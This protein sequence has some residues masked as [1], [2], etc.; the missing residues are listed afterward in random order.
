[1]KRLTLVV[2]GLAACTPASAL[3]AQELAAAAAVPGAA[4]ED[5][6]LAE[7]EAETIVVTGQRLEGAVIGDIPPEVTFSPADIRSFGVSSLNDL[8]AELAPQTGSS[9]GR[10]GESPVVLL[11][12]KR[13]SGFS[14]IRDIPTEAIQRVEILP[15]E[16]A[17]KYGYRATQ[18]V[19]N[20]V[21]RKRFRA[22]TGEL[23]AGAATEGG[24]FSPE[25][26]GSF[27]RIRDGGRLNIAFEYERSNALYE[28]DR[29]VTAQTPR[30]PYDSVGNIASAVSGA[31]ID[32]ALSAL[33][34]R[35]ATVV[36]VPATAASRAPTLADFAGGTVNAGD[37]GRYRTLAP[38][39][40]DFTLNAVY[41][42]S[43]FG[44]VSAS[45]NASFNYS[46]SDS[47]QGLAGV[48]LALPAGS[49]YSP[50]ASDSIVYR[51]LS[52]F[53]ALGQQ[54]R[55]MTGH[56]GAT[57]NGAVGAWNWTFTGNFDSKTSRTVT[58][59]GYDLD[60]FQ[61]RIDAFD[62]QANPFA[63][64]TAADAGPA[65]TDRARS[66]ANVGDAT[67]VV[68]GS[69]FS[70][71]AGTATTTVKIGGTTSDLSV[72]SVR[73]GITSAA[74][75]GRDTAS[76]QISFDLPLASRKKGILAPLGELSANFNIGY[77]HVSD[78]GGLRTIGAGISWTPV[79]P[80]RLI[81]SFSKDE[82]APT[83]QQL[84]NPLVATTGVRIFDYVQGETVDITR[85]TGGNP[86]LSA[87]DRRVLK[88]GATLKPITGTD[89]SLTANYTN[90]RVR[91]PI[92]S[93]PTAT[94]AI[95][96]AFPDRFTRDANGRIV[97]IDSRPI[98]FAR[99]DE[100]SL[101][102]GINF[103]KQ[104][105][106]PPR[107]TGGAEQREGQ[108]PNL[109]DL[110]P[111]GQN[112]GQQPNA[113]G[114][115]GNAGARGGF[116][117]PGGRPPGGGFGPGPGGRGTRLQLALYHTVHLRDEILIHQGGPALDLLNGDAIGSSGGQP[118]HELQAQAGLTRNGFGARLSADWRSGTTV[119]GGTTGAQALRFS[120]LTTVNL[121]LFANLGQQQALTGKWP[122][123]RGAR[124]SIAVDNL[125]NARM[126]VRDAT[127]ETPIS[128]QPGYID[129]VGRTIRISFRKLFF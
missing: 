108:Q 27:L 71:P 33:L 6:A 39:T 32:P 127:G 53:G 122:F 87:D 78:F 125:F 72:R 92:A 90:S 47:A 2:A 30:Q 88:L 19:V 38:E 18:K 31:E 35:P 9:Q 49:P 79:T 73:S 10:G 46:E 76:G 54:G 41:A 86:A 62:A 95:E 13:I 115:P 103:S 124:L 129:P 26:E 48:G 67:M 119:A 109:R 34:G 63:P 52:E 85:L 80:L 59:R 61:A 14:E 65:L 75:L 84:G 56:V 23:E 15:E 93:F 64:L 60:A 51:Y 83:I 112:A 5:G 121:R 29:N 120:D 44:N 94:A 111:P 17:L 37:V 118:R 96:A 36:G 81:A 57:L 3:F 77:D 69:L 45:F 106:T 102:W 99:Q 40:D 11:G 128:Y 55:D 50:F 82:G 114:G 25:V 42:R 20:V 8:L 43:I 107:P 89:L 16:V 117:G 66:T 91:D 100:E 113:P 105:S 123:L 4:H 104:L 12:G 126:N 98:N 97:Q 58:A 7:D 28:S 68:T 21:L 70:L 24:R 116:G 1:M 101:R 110:V 74:D 22:F